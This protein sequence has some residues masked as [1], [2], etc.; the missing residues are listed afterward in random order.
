MTPDEIIQRQSE[1]KALIDQA[2]AAAQALTPHWPTGHPIGIK[3]QTALRYLPAPPVTVGMLPTER[4]HELPAK[5]KPE[6]S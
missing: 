5:P 6:T 4:A 3:L 2:Y 1:L